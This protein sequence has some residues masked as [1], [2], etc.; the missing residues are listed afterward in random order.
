[1]KR[2]T[3]LAGL[4]AALMLST[5]LSPAWSPAWADGIRSTNCIAF[6]GMLSCTTKWQRWEPKEPPPPTE[7]ELAEMR[8]RERIWTER[9]KPVVHQDAYG[10]QRYTYAAPGC[11]FGRLR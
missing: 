3:T 9:C 4:A 7:Q 10:V 8:E 6:H 1:M 5:A 11:E 2:L